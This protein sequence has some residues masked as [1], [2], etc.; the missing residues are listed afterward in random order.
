MVVFSCPEDQGYHGKVIYMFAGPLGK[1]Y[2]GKASDA[3]KRIHRHRG[4]AYAKKDGDWVCNS[5]WKQAIRRIGWENL[6]V[7]ILEFVGEDESLEERERYWIA[8]LK[9]QDPDGYN[10][11]KGGGGPAPGAYKHTEEAKAKISAKMMGVGAKPVTSREIKHQFADGTQLVEFVLYASAAEAGR[12]TGFHATHIT[13]CCLEK[14]SSAGNCFWH[15]TKDG[16]LVGEHRVDNIRV[17][18]PPHARAVFS[19]SPGGKK[20][21]HEGGSAAGRTLSKSTGKKF[22]QS[23]ISACCKGER[24]HHHGYTFCYA[25]DEEAEIKNTKKRK[26]N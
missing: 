10:S 16:D 3:H 4:E 12:K 17:K 15:H 21:R 26:R 20:Q 9:T 14:V 23:A 7:V 1:G 22:S 18:P 6:R 24:T 13:A 2:I 11:N 19:T 25:S 5:I 8:K